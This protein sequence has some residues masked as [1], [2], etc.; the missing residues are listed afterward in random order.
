MKHLTID[1][2][3]LTPAQ[4]VDIIVAALPSTSQA[5][6]GTGMCDRHV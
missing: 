6:T 2:S 1:T 3:E 4:V 5:A